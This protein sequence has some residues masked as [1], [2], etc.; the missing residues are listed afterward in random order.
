M[1][2]TTDDIRALRRS[3]QRVTQTAVMGEAERAADALRRKDRSLTREQAI[4]RAFAQHPDWYDRYNGFAAPKPGAPTAPPTANTRLDS[5]DK[6]VA[7][8]KE[9]AARE[10][11]TFEVA[12]AFLVKNDPDARKIAVMRSEGL[13]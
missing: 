3:A 5:W 13:I 12:F 7:R 9:R 1:D 6:L 4:A 8:A 11:T 2:T 10:G